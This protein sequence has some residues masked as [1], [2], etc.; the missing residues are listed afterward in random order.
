M[1]FSLL[2]GLVAMVLGSAS[3]FQS[4]MPKGVAVRD[5]RVILA[6]H[7]VQNKGAKKARKNRPK[8]VRAA[9]ND[10]GGGCCCCCCCCV[11]RSFAQ[12]NWKGNWHSGEKIKI[13]ERSSGSTSK[14]MRKK[15]CLLAAG[16]QRRFM[17][18]S[19]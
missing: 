18:G 17:V 1:K 3:A 5:S 8:K 2:A 10:G 6:A 19:R 4:A 9:G 7:H 15:E 14:L 12:K 16:F 11:G 13:S